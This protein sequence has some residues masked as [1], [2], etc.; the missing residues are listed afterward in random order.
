MNSIKS[1]ENNYQKEK[2]N[3]KKDVNNINN[4]VYIRSSNI[5]RNLISPTKKESNIQKINSN[6]KE[7]AKN[8]KNNNRDYRISLNNTISAS[9]NM[10]SSEKILIH[11]NSYS[12][13]ENNRNNNYVRERVN[14]CDNLGQK[15]TEVLKIDPSTKERRMNY[16]NSRG[17]SNVLKNSPKVECSICH[18][19]VET[20]LIKIHINWH[21]T[22]VFNWLYLGTF[23]NASN[24]EEL[25]RIKIKY[26]LNC[27]SE[28]INTTL[29]KDITELHLRIR[30][31]TNFNLIS[32]LE[33]SNDFINKAK[34]SGGNIL[35][36]CKM[37]RSRS[38]SL[39]IAY[40]IKY[41][42]YNFNNALN[43]IKSKRNQINPNKGFI[44]Q[45]KQF[46]N[47]IKTRNKK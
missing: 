14:S 21:P 6:N 41:Q 5:Q 7:E 31:E 42:G 22:Q 17:Q 28:C 39:V 30:D 24:I 26:V 11:S 32:F 18:K 19:L 35:I 38:V 47:T 44:E 16:I 1:I 46:E 23:S 8:E 10:R 33:Q 45:L 15:S 9:R 12:N 40:L 4:K 29:P 27:A 20:Y 2:E 37:G 13:N 36:H 3:N 43:F 34:L 25:R